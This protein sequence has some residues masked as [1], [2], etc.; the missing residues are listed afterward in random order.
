M[1]FLTNS[2]VSEA[3]KKITKFVIK[4]GFHTPRLYGTLIRKDWTTSYGKKEKSRTN[5]RKICDL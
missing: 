2:N 4:L 1:A 5:E 3:Y